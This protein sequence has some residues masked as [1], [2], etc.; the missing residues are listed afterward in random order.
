MTTEDPTAEKLSPA[1]N[2]R[3]LFAGADRIASTEEQPVSNLAR[4]SLRP[5]GDAEKPG[6]HLPVVED[7]ATEQ[8]PPVPAVRLSSRAT[9]EEESTSQTATPDVSKA[10]ATSG[11]RGALAKIGL[12]VPPSKADIA[13]AEY[14][15]QLSAAQT[16]V[17]TGRWPRAVS[18]LVANKKGGSGKSPLA[19]SL[20]GVLASVRGGGVA[21]LEISDD[22]GALGYR[23]EGDTGAATLGL[24]D[25]LRDL[26]D[27]TTAGALD[28]YALPQSS[29]NKVFASSSIRAALTGENVTRVAA[30]LDRFYNV[31]IMDSGNQITS[32]AF[33]AGLES[34]D[35]LVVP[36]MN[37]GDSLIEAL[38]MIDHLSSL[39]GKAQRL[40]Q[41]AVFVRIS[42]GRPEDDQV[43]SRI[44]GLL[45]KI[46]NGGVFELPFDAHIA[47]RSEI[48]L[49]KLAPA[50]VNAITLIAA[51]AFRG[52]TKN[53]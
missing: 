7:D 37:A 31:R 2:A 26:E 13:R 50:T 4:R 19:L 30:L 35:V 32:A 11:I 14:A 17:L 9:W 49:S 21:T 38:D 41:N 53:I 47:E 20:G 18:I 51:A 33:H 29:S 52:I 15:A 27:V 12:P 42:D 1:A 5:T 23:A 25:L 39:G 10:R 24:P 36:V 48:V 16:E 6:T 22:P 3:A 34:A 8:E 46:E 45:S 28:N 43:R 44:A 40:A